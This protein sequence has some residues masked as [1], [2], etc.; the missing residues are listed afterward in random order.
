MRYAEPAAAAPKKNISSSVYNQQSFFGIG[1]TMA[2][3][4][5]AQSF[6]RKVNRTEINVGT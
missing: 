4:A 3:E 6:D 2:L 5:T 1:N